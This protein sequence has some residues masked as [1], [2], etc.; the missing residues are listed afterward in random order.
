MTIGETRP[1]TGWIDAHLGSH[2][3]AAL[4]ANGGV[5]GHRVVRVQGPHDAVAVEGLNPVVDF[6]SSRDGNRNGVIASRGVPWQRLLSARWA[7]TSACEWIVGCVLGARVV[8]PRVTALLPREV[9]WVRPRVLGHLR[10]ASGVPY[11]S[12]CSLPDPEPAAADVRSPPMRVSRTTSTSARAA[13]GSGDRA[14]KSAAPYS[15]PR[16]T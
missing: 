8:G 2:V 5:F 9:A 11:R 16:A 3:A 15:P 13:F 4:D 1:I 7:D 12:I 10:L 6:R 14:M